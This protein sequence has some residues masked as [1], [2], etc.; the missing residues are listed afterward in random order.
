M[1]PELI[2]FDLCPFVQRSVITMLEKNVDCKITYIDLAQ[3]PDWFLKISP[4]GKVPAL[5]VGDVTLFESAVINEYLD[6]ITPPSM[7]P[8]DPLLRA[9]NRA[10]IEF[11]SDLI[12]VQYML[13]IA[14]DAAAYEQRRAELHKKL[15]RLEANLN[16]GP[17]FN[18][19]NFSLI[20]C[21]FAPM[22]MRLDLLQQRVDIGVYAARPKLS[23]WAAA[24]RI[25][26]SVTRSVIPQFSEKF[27]A[28][29]QNTGTYAGKLFS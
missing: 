13:S 8:R 7:H 9:L 17:F 26:P 14:P 20:D 27:R 12:G 28:Y 15:D 21:A 24:L 5:R 22:F 18:G 29:L 23:E 19:A 6:D 25:R 1:Q 2:S 16:R 4:F 10:W 3:P 11:G